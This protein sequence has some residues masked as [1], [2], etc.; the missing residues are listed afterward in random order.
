M[1]AREQA[2]LYRSGILG[3]FEVASTRYLVIVSQDYLEMPSALEDAGVIYECLNIA[4]TPSTPS[5]AARNLTRV[6][7]SK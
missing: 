3:G 6:Q 2:R 5:K 7:N 1:A 4:V